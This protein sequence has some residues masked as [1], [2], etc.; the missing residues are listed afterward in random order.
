MEDAPR[1]VTGGNHAI[2][3]NSWDDSLQRVVR[4]L[5]GP[6]I[7]I[8]KCVSCSSLTLVSPVNRNVKRRA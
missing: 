4:A 7:G 5:E 1:S 8:Q 2:T 3:T 6:L